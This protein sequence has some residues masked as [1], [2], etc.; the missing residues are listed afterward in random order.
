[1]GRFLAGKNQTSF[2]FESGTYGTVSG[3]TQ[4]PGEVQGFD[5]SDTENIQRIRYHGTNT[6]NLAKSVPGVKDY[7]FTF[8]QFPQHFKFLMLA[9]GNCSDTTTGSPT[10]YSHVL[11]QLTSC[12]QSPVVSGPK[13]PFTSFSMESAQ[14]CNPTG[15]NLNRLYNGCNVNSYTLAK[16]DNSAPLVETVEVLAQSR[17]FSSGA[18][19]FTSLTEIT[20]RPHAPFDSILHFPSGTSMDAKTWEFNYGNNFDKDGSH[21]SNGSRN[22]NAAAATETN[23]TVSWAMDGDSAHAARLFGLFENGGL[24]QEN[25]AIQVN[26]YGNA[27]SGMAWITVS[28]CDVEMTAPNP[29]EGVDEWSISLTGQVADA[30]VQDS[31]IKYLPW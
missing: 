19:T 27:A 31:I 21:V 12:E 26:N 5:P 4:W 2:Q 7:G 24:S 14:Q 23:I 10:Y 13:C 11:T 6:R 16:T 20:R 29:T 17:T 18:P 9:L 1:M 30:I 28:G 25:V 22:P 15:G 8:E 3:A